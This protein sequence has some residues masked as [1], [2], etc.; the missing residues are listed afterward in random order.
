VPGALHIPLDLLLQ[1]ENLDRLPGDGKIVVVCHSG[2][3][4][5]VATTLLKAIGFGNV[6]YLDGGVTALANAVTPKSL[7]VE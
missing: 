7:P 3:R 4:A 2:S 5:V 6:V 1:K